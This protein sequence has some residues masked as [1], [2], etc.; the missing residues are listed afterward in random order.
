MPDTERFDCVIMPG[1]RMLSHWWEAHRLQGNLHGESDV[2]VQQPESFTRR[3]C[4]LPPATR[5]HCTV[6]HRPVWSA[7]H[8][9]R[10]HD[11]LTVRA[12][13]VDAAHPAGITLSASMPR[14]AFAQGRWR[15]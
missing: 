1:M 11:D 4:L 12:T 14:N 9:R 2:S 6:P 3:L 5:C 8:R 13:E 7:Q 15:H 10:I